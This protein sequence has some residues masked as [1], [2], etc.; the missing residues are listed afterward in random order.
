MSCL[1]VFLSP[2][3]EKSISSLF[4]FGKDYATLVSYVPK[5]RKV[6]LLLSTMHQSNAI[7]PEIGDKKKTEAITFYNATKS[8][9]DT[10]N[11]MSGSYSVARKSQRWPLTVFY[12][13]LNIAAINTLI[14]VARNKNRKCHP[15]IRRKFLKE[16]ALG[17][18]KP[19]IKCR[20]K[21][22]NLN[23]KLKSDILELIKEPDD[24]PENTEKNIESSNKRK[25]C[26]KCPRTG[27]KTSNYCA[28]CETPICGKHGKLTCYDCLKQA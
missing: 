13:M 18:V 23:I 8:G 17:L 28:I 10:V 27:N 2:V 19:Y 22:P 1:Y 20:F 7:D 26:G 15:I 25:R 6:V 16:L 14:I 11:E 12:N 4:G 5:K 24:N 9:V 3:V 21:P